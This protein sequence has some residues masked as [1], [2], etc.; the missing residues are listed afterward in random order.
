LP[1]ANTC[2]HFVTL[3]KSRGTP[4]TEIGTAKSACMGKLPRYNPRTPPISLKITVANVLETCSS[5]EFMVDQW[6]LAH[7]G[8][9]SSTLVAKRSAAVLRS[10]EKDRPR[11]PVKSTRSMRQYPSIS[12]VKP[13]PRGALFH[14]SR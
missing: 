10:Y 4:V 8:P 14:P 1:T 6:G 3:S 13:P 11:S 9:F 12:I 5:L 2:R 7:D